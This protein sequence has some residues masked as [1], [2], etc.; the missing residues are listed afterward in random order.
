MTLRRKVA[1]AFAAL[2][3]AAFA[4]P[5]VV[6]AWS[7]DP[8][9]GAEA[10]AAANRVAT[11]G[12]S[13]LAAAV[14][15]LWLF[16]DRWVLRPAV[17]M[18]A[19]AQSLAQS[20]HTERPLKMPARHALGDIPDSFAALADA[21]RG[22]RQEMVQATRT[23][24]AQVAE[25]KSWLEVILLD[26][27]EGVVVC[28]TAHQVLLYNQA[29]VR[30]LDAPETLGLGRSLFA[31]LTRDPV[32]H[33]YEL[34]DHR[35]Q[36]SQDGAYE[37]SSPFMC[38]TADSRIMLQGRM[39]LIVDAAR[40]PS[41]YAL[42]L[43][44]ISGQL[45]SLNKSDA[46][47]RAITRDLRGPIAALR[48][49]AET[50]AQ[51]P[52]MEPGQRAAFDRAVLKEAMDLSETIEALAAAYRG[53]ALGRWPMADIHS[54]DLF[55]CVARH[56]AD[57]L[58]VTVT[59]I[60]HPLWLQGDSHALM[61][62]LE[63]LV[64]R[65]HGHTGARAFDVE[66]LLG[67]RRVY[68]DVVW[69]GE[70]IPSHVLDQWLDDALDG[71][72]ERLSLRDVLDRHG[73]E[74]WSLIQ[75]QGRA[76][77]RVPM[78]APARPQFQAPAAALPPRPEF[79]D[80]GLMH[81]YSVAGELGERRLA[82]LEFV[83]FDT[84][85]TGLQPTRGDEIIAIAGI[86]VVRRRVLTGETFERLVHPGRPIPPESIRFHGIT[87][88]MVAGKPPIEVV[89]PQF[90][91]FVGDGVLVA[92]NAAFDIKFLRMKEPVSG[93]AL[94]NP[95]MD[96]LVLSLLLDGPQAE[97]SL[98]AIAERL[99]V[100]V[101]DRHTALGDARATAEILVRMIDRLEAKGIVTLAQAMEASNM[102]VE[103]REREAAF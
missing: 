9:A 40:R 100:Q 94:R 56:V 82:E 92:H 86:R 34:L 85:T 32:L 21:M 75:R 93:V 60:G 77:L 17:V 79:Y 55:N 33:T 53:H 24:T 72:L 1:L 48:A 97:H 45:E 4:A 58:G 7:G 2:A 6:L 68:L 81:E 96:T 102:T 73:S 62:T 89:L 66:A 98:D 29:A 47:R 15:A 14:L 36:A 57:R 74:L 35:R 67:D 27:S 59:L 54:P 28:N 103:M 31:V 19:D 30:M 64:A 91:A 13:I 51:F 50:V 95:V 39:A 44:D 49:A 46:V 99:G 22:A 26:L 71:A 16:L 65:L 8:A 76:L 63:H 83:V 70:P 5:L 42:T 80:F 90:R 87:D 11:M 20:P 61:L 38:A 12:G 3:V 88:A 52:N 69:E 43:V 23:A 41:G 101:K 78:L 37:L 84:E 18:A 10:K 25:Q